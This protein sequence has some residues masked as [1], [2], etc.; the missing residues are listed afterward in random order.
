MTAAALGVGASE[1]RPLCALSEA[2][3]LALDADAGVPLRPDPLSDLDPFAQARA[4]AEARATLLAR[5]LLAAAAGPEPRPAPELALVL[6]ARRAPERVVA[7]EGVSAQDPLS[8]QYF[9]A[10]ARAGGF[11][12]ESSR[13]GSRQF[14]LAGPDRV[15]A[16]ILE[17]LAP[18]APA[19]VPP[20]AGW[21]GLGVG[22][23]AQEAMGRVIDGASRITRVMGV[24][25]Q[26]GGPARSVDF[27]VVIDGEAR[28]RVVRQHH[29]SD[30]AAP[31][32]E[33]GAMDGDQLRAIVSGLVRG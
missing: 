10:T 17:L 21:V 30:G 3:W 16:E 5:G 11:V 31:T 33:V 9:G 12:V 23:A 4:R 6:A 20:G 19:P 1:V 32:L 27:T 25:L 24:V 22:E 29:R 13:G 26:A 15:V 8:R 18:S 14:T 28:A 7:L 2:E